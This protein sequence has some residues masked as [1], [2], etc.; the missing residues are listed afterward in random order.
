M[1][2]ARIG[3][4]VE[5]EMLMDKY[6]DWL[7]NEDFPAPIVRTAPARS[8]PK[9]SPK[10][11]RNRR[12]SLPD[13][14]ATSPSIRPGLPSIP[15]GGDDDIFTMD[16]V[17]ALNLDST[18]VP[19]TPAPAAA[20]AIESKGGSPWKSQTAPQRFVISLQSLSY[21]S[22]FIGSVDLKS[23]LAETEAKT[24][25][26][27]SGVYRPPSKDASPAAFP[28]IGG[29]SLPS[30]LPSSTSAYR[31]ASIGLQTPTRA[32][33]SAQASATP[34]QRSVTVPKSPPAAAPV[35]GLG[36]TITPTK[37]TRPSGPVVRNASSG[38]GRA[39]TL[40]PVRP[41]V[42]STPSATQL[43]SFAEIQRLQREQDAGPV[44][45]KRSLKEIQ[46]EERER[47]QEN[48]FMRWWAEEEERVRQEQEAEARSIQRAMDKGN[49]LRGKKEGS[50]KEGKPRKPSGAKK[51][52]TL[53]QQSATEGPGAPSS[54]AP[55][56]KATG[57]PRP[58][59]HRNRAPR[60]EPTDIANSSHA[61]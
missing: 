54:S 31:P 27:A 26:T 3:T 6:K 25:P 49:K 10:A 32:R 58:Q 34:P 23:I 41:V 45:D 11:S 53:L 1:R 22:Y 60:K 59:R 46:D 33:P 21:Y 13:S 30:G 28:P 4:M 36:P 7:D 50:G 20:A 24:R 16:D 12:T 9:L 38:G 8:S 19:P 14:P 18:S 55:P 43:L 39:W 52:D 35:P 40:A 44:R 61:H 56:A 17:P 2:R 57:A 37:Q 51:S 48:D 42:Q 15:T 47:Q 29:S 5:V